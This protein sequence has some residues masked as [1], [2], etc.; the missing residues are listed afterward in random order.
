MLLV[1]VLIVLVICI[2]WQCWPE[3]MKPDRT[4]VVHTFNKQNA[5]WHR[6]GYTH[7]PFGQMFRSNDQMYKNWEA[8]WKLV[9]LGKAEPI[10]DPM[11]Y[12]ALNSAD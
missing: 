12:Y 5:S 1:G 8:Y 4:A 6:H 9:D 7:P 2:I 3:R 11:A 10:R